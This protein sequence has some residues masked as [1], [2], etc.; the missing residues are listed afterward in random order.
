MAASL[1]V[2]GPDTTLAHCTKLDAE[3]I[4]LLADTGAR[5]AHCPISNA[6]LCSGFMP[7]KE[8]LE[9]GVHIGLATDGPASHNTLD[10]FQEMKF[11]A[12]IHKNNYLDPELLPIRQMLEMATSQAAITMHR[13]DTGYLAEGTAADV[14]V[15]DTNKPHTMPLYDQEAAL[16]YSSR[17]DDVTHTIV[18]GQLLMENRKVVGIDEDEILRELRKRALLLKKRS[19]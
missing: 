5:V 11:A 12:L 17:A 13:T 1:G 15:V 4:R 14:I 6:K 9:A 7:I 3:D 16:V 8:M 19:L 18:D 2:L 10:M